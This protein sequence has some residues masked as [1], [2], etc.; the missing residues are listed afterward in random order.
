MDSARVDRWLWAVRI[1][2][3]RTAATQACR[4]GHVRVNGTRAK[5][6][7]T[8]GIGDTI[9]VTVGHRRRVVDVVR[10]IDRRVGAPIA[11]ECLIDRSP[12]PPPRQVPVAVRDRGSGRPSKRERRQLERW[13]RR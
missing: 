10:V 2:P 7:A 13:R 8:V 4:G 11:A 5:P 3:T 9:E 6:A 1:Y 12:P